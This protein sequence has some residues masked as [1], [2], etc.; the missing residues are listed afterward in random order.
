MPDIKYTLTWI[1]E[2][3]DI[4]MKF[5]TR[6]LSSELF[7]LS[8]GFMDESKNYFLICTRI[9]YYLCGWSYY[10]LLNVRNRTIHW[11]TISFCISVVQKV[12]E[13]VGGCTFFLFVAFL[14]IW[15]EIYIYSILTSVVGNRINIKSRNSAGR[16][17][18]QLLITNR[19]VPFDTKVIFG[20]FRGKSS[21]WYKSLKQ[22]FKL[23]TNRRTQSG[24]SWMR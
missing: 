3:W 15:Q 17:C 4:F 10:F 16:A 9:C 14:F 12:G 22:E 24:S 23:Q 6:T 19:N 13:L 21:H 8:H 1:T 5:R 2:T 11:W 18:D 7:L 20:W